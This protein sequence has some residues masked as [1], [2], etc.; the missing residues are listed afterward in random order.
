M[1]FGEDV[2]ALVI[3]NGTAMIKAGFA[4]GDAPRSVFPTVIA[5]TKEKTVVGDEA[6]YCKD[7][8]LER[9]IERGIIKN[10]EDMT[11]IWKN[12]YDEL[13]VSPDEHPV[14]LTEIPLN[15]KAN[16]EKMVDIFFKEF[17]V[18]GV[19][20]ASQPALALYTSGRVTGCVF[21][22][23]F[24]VSHAVC[25]YE[26]H[27]LSHTIQRMEMGGC[28]LTAHLLKL[29]TERGY[30]FTNSPKDLEIIRDI[31]EKLCFVSLDFD[32]DV[33]LAAMSSGHEKT[34]E[35]PD[36]DVILIGSEQ[37][38]CPELLFQ[39]KIFGF[40][41]DSITTLVNSAILHCDNDLR[42]EMFKNIVLSGGNT[43]FPGI[44][45]RLERELSNLVLDVNIKVV[46]PP[47]R[48]YSAYIGGA[49]TAAMYN[50]KDWIT[51]EE[52]EEV[53]ASVVRK[54]F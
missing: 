28:D 30:E 36:G 16:R 40:D 45:T 2:C 48:K 22:S 18:L 44:G 9:P 35:L 24:G 15:P 47:E 12:V 21:D 46:T 10:W 31:K 8:Q 33:R 3:D 13:R 25:I 20:I 29:L 39:P 7:V 5:R 43:M 41:C 37:F 54:C 27:V 17:D 34:F 49:L 38:I 53:G 26:G 50:F 51:K 23:G 19:Y 14:L 1:M 32:D 42:L 11:K 6:Y 52:Y 4:G